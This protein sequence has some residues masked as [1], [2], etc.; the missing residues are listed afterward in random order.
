MDGFKYSRHLDWRT[1]L[2][3]IA[4][5]VS[6]ETASTAVEGWPP[7]SSVRPLFPATHH[8]GSAAVRTT[9]FRTGA[10][11]PKQDRPPTM[12][13]SPFP[14]PTPPPS[15]PQ[16]EATWATKAFTADSTRHHTPQSATFPKNENRSAARPSPRPH[17]PSTNAD[18][19]YSHS[20]LPPPER[21]QTPLETAPRWRS[22]TYVLTTARRWRNSRRAVFP[23]GRRGRPPPPG[24][25]LG[26]AGH[27]ESGL[28]LATAGPLR[29]ILAVARDLLP[30]RPC[31]V[32]IFERTAVT[33]FFTNHGEHNETAG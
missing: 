32:M 31:A 7:A 9:P 27:D 28:S 23:S 25:V 20:Q 21:T 5:R 33:T 18:A 8:H 22:P 29:R 11:T 10:R 19:S 2:S 1:P 6:A 12:L 15:T 3:R 24:E 26:A 16:P 17:L 13:R 14:I 30:G 4:H